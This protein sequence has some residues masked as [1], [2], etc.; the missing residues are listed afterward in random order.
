MTGRLVVFLLLLAGAF[1]GVGVRLWA[2]QVDRHEHYAELAE[3][4]QQRVVELNPPRGTLYDARGRELAVSSPTDS[5]Y[6]VPR[7]IDDAEATAR[8]LAV[9][10]GIDAREL[11]PRLAGHGWFAWVERQVEPETAAAVAALALPGIGLREESK[12][13]YPQGR[14]A[15]HVLGFVGTD[16]QGLAGLEQ[17]FNPQVTGKVGRRVVLR[18]AGGRYAVDPDL[19]LAEA[20]PGADLHLTLDATLQHIV[21]RELEATARKFRA[22]AGSA[23]LLDP[24]SGAVLAMA[25]YPSFDPNHFRH[26]PE[27]EE[28]WRNRAVTDVF[29][30]GSAFKMVTAAAALENNLVDPDDVLDCQ[31]GRIVVYGVPIRDHKPFGRLTFRQVIA[32]SSN[33]GAIKVGL[34]VG[35][36]RLYRQIVDLGFGARTGI[37]LPGE[38]PGLL[39]PVERWEPVT[40]AYASFGQGVAVTS[41][42]LAAAFGAVANGG[43]LLKPYLVAAID[44]EGALEELHARPEVVRRAMSPATAFRL[45][46]MLEAVVT[47]GTGTRAAVPGYAVAGKTG[48]A[49]MA[50]GGGYSATDHKAVFAGFAPA[51]DPV[52]VGAVIVDRPRTDIHGGQVAA[53]LFSAIAREAL[54]YLGV[55]PE[56]E[57]PEPW[58]GQTGRR[59]RLAAADR[60]P[61]APAGVAVLAHGATGVEP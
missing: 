39:R 5:I 10:L 53:P 16:A 32:E 57:P 60:G 55:R 40:K 3:K 8:E 19:S 45:E 52:L 35:D 58:P 6:A 15:A 41:L 4:Q 42:Q 13:Y 17:T 51:R 43:L 21:E 50:D 14:L 27:P 26:G 24:H 61:A 56:R 46:R 23:V 1:A 11:A 47:E 31:Q 2:L 38:S 44:R 9:V 25:S 18:D 54:L 59:A 37:E 30:P 20:E 49:Q 12:R 28:R 33:V 34:R 36:E 22:P 29:E 7:E 48:T